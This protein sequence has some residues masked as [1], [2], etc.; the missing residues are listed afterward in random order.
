[1]KRWWEIH[2]IRSLDGLPAFSVGMGLGFEF[3]VTFHR[4]LRGMRGDIPGSQ[5]E[6]ARN[7][8]SSHR[9]INS[10]ALPPS[11]A[12]DRNLVPK[13]ISS[14]L[15][16]IFKTSS[17]S[18]ILKGYHSRIED[19]PSLVPA[20]LPLFIAFILGVLVGQMYNR[21]SHFPKEFESVPHISMDRI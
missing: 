17:V 8:K 18:H 15:N 2:N 5:A 12:S 16:S 19:L 10:T 21:P 6:V 20:L 14:S 9:V 4:L 3:E 11:S 1:M 13:M 7:A